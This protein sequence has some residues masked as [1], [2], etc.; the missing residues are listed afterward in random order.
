MTSPTSMQ[1]RAHR[2]GS[3]SLFVMIVVVAVITL[4]LIAGTL[5]LTG[6]EG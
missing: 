2:Q 6:A 5:I 4:A 1:A 3:P